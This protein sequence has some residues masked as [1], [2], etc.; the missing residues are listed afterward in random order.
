MHWTRFPPLQRNPV[1]SRF[2]VHSSISL[3]QWNSIDKVLFPWGVTRAI[4]L[5]IL[6]LFSLLWSVHSEWPLVSSILIVPRQIRFVVGWVCR[7]LFSVLLNLYIP[8]FHAL[9]ESY[10]RGFA[11]SNTIPFLC[12]SNFCADRDSY[13]PNCR[14]RTVL[15]CHRILL[16]HPLDLI[17]LWNKLTVRNLN[18]LC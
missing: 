11:C 18:K 7:F 4:W 13:F 1:L 15:N 17:N 10:L 9:T 5:V 2:W 14:F 3:S 8:L 6:S 16:I 12:L